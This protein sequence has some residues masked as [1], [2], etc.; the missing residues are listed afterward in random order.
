MAAGDVLFFNQFILD[1][2]NKLHDLD[3]DDWRIGLV[4]TA[5]VPAKTTAAPH[6]GGTGTTNF[7]TN[8]IATATSYAAPIVMTAETYAASS[9][10]L[11]W[12][13]GKIGPIAQDAGGATNIA[14]GI[15]YINTDANKRAA[16]AVELSSTGA[17][18]LVAGPLEIRWNSVDGTGQI[19]RFAN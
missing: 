5:T 18:S 6:W 13:A 2:G 15:V 10:D 9:N 14:Y 1:L 12:S 16:C 17:I 7:A 11:I 19:G 3:S 8:Q 4:T